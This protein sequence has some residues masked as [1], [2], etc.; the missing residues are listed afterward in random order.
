V[1]HTVLAG[2]NTQHN[3]RNRLMSLRRL[4]RVGVL[5]VRSGKVGKPVPR[6]LFAALCGRRRGSRSKP[7]LRRTRVT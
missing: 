6:V 1:P 4:R 7:I 2:E 3:R 5:A